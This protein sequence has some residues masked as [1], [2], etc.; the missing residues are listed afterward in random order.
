MP[1]PP[2]LTAAGMSTISLDEERRR[3]RLR[4]GT[5]SC[6]EC[7]HFFI[8]TCK[9][10]GAVTFLTLGTRVSSILR[11][12]PTEIANEA[13]VNA[14]KYAANSRLI[15]LFAQAVL[16]E[17]PPV[18]TSLLSHFSSSCSQLQV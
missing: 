1:V 3:K 7:E 17:G 14:A 4:K 12:N 2:A 8:S 9:V 6:W 16:Q 13:Q 5:F 11:R 10:P 18:R 15:T